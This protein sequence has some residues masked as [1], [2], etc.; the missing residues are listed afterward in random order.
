VVLARVVI[1][2]DSNGNETIQ[3]SLEVT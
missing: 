2:L 3:A 1:T